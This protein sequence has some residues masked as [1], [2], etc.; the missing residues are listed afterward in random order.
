[1]D[2]LKLVR[3]SGL[4]PISPSGFLRF[5]TR[6]D[7]PEEVKSIKDGFKDHLSQITDKQKDLELQIEQTRRNITES[8][9]S[10]FSW[11]NI[12]NQAE[13]VLSLIAENDPQALKQAYHA[14]FSKVVVGDEDTNG[15]RPIEYVLS[16]IAED[17]DCGPRS[18]M[19]ETTAYQ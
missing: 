8:R 4:Y 17:D 16:E 5:C 11:N 6:H 15:V 12:G 14:L 1:M 7:T 2:R 10:K 9:G 3:T 19:V 18:E 13:R